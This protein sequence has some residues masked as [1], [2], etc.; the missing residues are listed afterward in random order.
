MARDRQEFKRKN[1]A[2]HMTG[3]RIW[4]P[5]EVLQGKAW[6]GLSFSGK[7]LLFDL[8]AQLRARHGEIYNNGD[9]T[10]ALEV[11]R[12]A[13]WKRRGTILVAAKELETVC[14]ICKTRQGRLPNLATLYAVTWLP[15]NE[16]PKLDI[17][18]RGFPFR[19]YLLHNP[20]P[21]LPQ[22]VENGKRPS[23]PSTSTITVLGHAAN[24]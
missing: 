23:H 15:L 13:G 14:L 20:P 21:A 7:A 4:I 2:G 10:T 6:A 22:N 11:L 5:L 18:A 8:A 16:S 1:S 19:G 17:S 3:P 12:P 9:L 24:L